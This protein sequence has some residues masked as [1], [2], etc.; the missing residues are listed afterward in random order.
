MLVLRT[1]LLPSSFYLRMVSWC[2]F[3][4]HLVSGCH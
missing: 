4:E 1:L 3:I 2:E